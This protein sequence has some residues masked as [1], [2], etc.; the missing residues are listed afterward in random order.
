MLFLFLFC[1][2]VGTG[3]QLEFPDFLAFHLR[4][5]FNRKDGG[6]EPKVQACGPPSFVVGYEGDFSVWSVLRA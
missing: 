5:N 1:G 4:G 3:E 2:E 6:L